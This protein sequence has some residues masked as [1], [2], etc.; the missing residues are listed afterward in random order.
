[1]QKPCKEFKTSLINISLSFFSYN[2]I[3]FFNF[4][5]GIKIFDSKG[6]FLKELKFLSLDL[7]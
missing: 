3:S 5:Q 4:K 7:Y 6:E 1:M 2:F